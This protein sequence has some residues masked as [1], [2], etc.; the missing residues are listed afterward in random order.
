MKILFFHYLN[1][2]LKVSD[3]SDDENEFKN[4]IIENRQIP[5]VCLVIRGDLNSI[6]AI[7]S[8]IQREIPVIIL[9]GSGAVSDIIAFASYELNE[10]Y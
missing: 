10:K 6:D 4:P 3:A 9:K 2:N 5:M 7:D 1:N 8:K